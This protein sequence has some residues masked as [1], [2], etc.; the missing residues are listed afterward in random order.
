MRKLIFALIIG[1]FAGLIIGLTAI[2]PYLDKSSNVSGKKGNIGKI[3][4]SSLNYNKES[5]IEGSD[6]NGVSLS[7]I[8]LLSKYK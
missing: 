8:I 4:Q 6:L 5:E 3:S 1:L 2:G 7:T